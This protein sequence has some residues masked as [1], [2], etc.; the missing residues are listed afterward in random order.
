MEPSKPTAPDPE[1]MLNLSVKDFTA[2]TAAKTPIPGGGSVAGAVGGLAAALG[3]MSLVFT[4]G[5]KQFAAHAAEHQALTVRLARARGM[6]IDLTSDDASAYT[7]YQEATRCTDATKDEKTRL[8]LAAAIDVPRQMTA[9]A[10]TVLDDLVALSRACNPWLLSDLAAAAVLAESV[11]RLS[12]LN[13]RVNAKN[14]PDA[15]A[16]GDL[17]QASARDCRRA[18]ELRGEVE[19]VVAQHL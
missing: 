16:A 3:E 2:A 17:R 12:D 4:L 11:V 19:K 13:V 9:L 15:A 14:V 6:F 10:I 7:L 8:A 18:A 1:Q 5:K